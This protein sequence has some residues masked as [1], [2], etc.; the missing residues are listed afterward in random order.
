M[1]IDGNHFF[2]VNHVEIPHFVP[3]ARAKHRRRPFLLRP[4][5][6]LNPSMRRLRCR[7]DGAR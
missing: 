3:H 1:P 6:Q 5:Q 7:K 4:I 2:A